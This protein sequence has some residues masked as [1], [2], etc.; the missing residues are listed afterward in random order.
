MEA[1]A[2]VTL[3]SHEY[4][5]VQQAQDP[6]L[7]ALQE[8]VEEAAQDAEKR[9]RAELDSAQGYLDITLDS[10]DLSRA[11]EHWANALECIEKG[12]LE[13]LVPEL[14]VSGNVRGRDGRVWAGEW[15]GRESGCGRE[16]GGCACVVFVGFSLLVLLANTRRW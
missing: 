5:C 7:V 10:F 13:A 15:R 16:S 6:W 14:A 3:A 11:Q 9:A 1:R 2:L 4:A 8:R 12:G